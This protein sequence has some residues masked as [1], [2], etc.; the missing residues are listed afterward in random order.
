LLI[1]SSAVELHDL[2]WET[3]RDPRD[4]NRWLV[5]SNRLLFSRFLARFEWR[6]VHLRRKEDLSAL[7]VIANPSNSATWNLA[8]ID[9]SKEWNLAQKALAPFHVV[10]IRDGGPATMNRLADHLRESEFDILYLVGH[11]AL[12]EG[13]PWLW[14]ENETGE[15]DRINGEELVARLG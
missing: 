4:R 5:T 14:L 2:R 1:D 9:V 13:H 10:N 15:A 12:V 3:L 8:P 6:P 11:G 7:V